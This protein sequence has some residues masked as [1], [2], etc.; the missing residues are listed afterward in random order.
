M[1]TMHAFT[2]SDWVKACADRYLLCGV[3][4]G[5]AIEF[6]EQCAEMQEEENGDFSAWISPLQAA[7]DDM[8]Y[9]SDDE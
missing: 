4:Q 9:W 5:T 7:D 2:R 6:A 3:S 1:A 8:G